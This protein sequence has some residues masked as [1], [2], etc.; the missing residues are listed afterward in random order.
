MKEQISAL[1]DEKIKALNLV[2]SNVQVVQEDG[3]K[4]LEIE[5][6]STDIIDLDRVT[7][8]TEIINPIL[9]AS[10]L[11]DATIDVVDI[12]GKSKEEVEK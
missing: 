2:V 5:L 3:V 9:D 11:I 12:Y 4:S 6:D 7:Q 8:A 1:V 10:G